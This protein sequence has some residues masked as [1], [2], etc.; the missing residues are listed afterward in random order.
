M[1]R[2]WNQQM[3]LDATFSFATRLNLQLATVRWQIP[4]PDSHV[5]RDTRRHEVFDTGCGCGRAT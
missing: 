5:T 4:T 3:E 1:L 2:I